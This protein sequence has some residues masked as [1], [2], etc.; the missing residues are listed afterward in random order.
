MRVARHLRLIAVA[1]VAAC[2]SNSIDGPTTPEPTATLDVQ[3]RQAIQP[4]GVVPLLPV[5]ENNA[6]LVDLGRALFFDKALSGNRDVACAT[7]HNPATEAGDGRS[8]AVGTGA[9]VIGGLR[10]LGVGRQF[11]PRNAPSLFNSGLGLF[12]MFWDGRVSEFGGPTG[13]FR[14][15][16]D[17]TLPAGVSTLLAAQAMLPVTNRVEM[18]G[19]PGDKDVFGNANELALLPDTANAA[20]WNAVMRRLLSYSGYVEKFNAAYPGIPSTSLGFEHAA[21]AIAAFERAAFAK[22]NTTF[23]RFLQHEDNAI[24]VDAKRGAL[25]FFGRGTCSSCHNG[26]LLGGSGF[27]S[28]GTPQ[29]GPG[30]GPAAPLDGGGDPFGGG[31]V[32]ATGPRFQFRVPAL[33]NVELTAPYMHNGAYPTLEAVVRH[34]SNVDSAVTSYDVTQLE[35]AL[36]STYHGDADTRQKL[37]AS[38]DFRLR[39]NLGFTP[40]EQRQLVAFLKSLT[41]P[42]ARDL[43]GVKPASV[44]SGLPVPD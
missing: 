1:L 40:E 43:S 32:T 30:T 19:E 7:C 24:S 31:V 5:V 37:L 13:R 42:A 38:V 2:D 28:D 29:L 10:T 4:W 25:L 26:A 20:I 22:T 6:A 18:R 35:P 12:Y 23:D 8:L 21:N 3:V 16:T 44:P 9:V 33:R 17:V 11:T 14:T 15:P 39:R 41:D 27:A 36:R 34:Y